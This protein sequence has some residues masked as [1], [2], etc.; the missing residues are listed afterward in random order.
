M[1]RGFIA[2][3][4][5]SIAAA[6]VT[7]AHAADAGD[8]AKGKQVFARCK[9]CHTFDP[10]GKSYMGPDLY[11]VVGRKAATLPGFRYS[12]A[13]KKAS[14]DG[15]VWTP[16][17]LDTWLT[18]PRAMIPGTHMQFAGIRKAQDRADVIAYLGTSSKP[19]SGN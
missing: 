7:S 4:A 14:A 8:A 3:A 16:E 9:Q 15:L 19:A 17:K 6:L 12:N 18:N 13:M 11:G 2:A 5:M 1:R 10:N